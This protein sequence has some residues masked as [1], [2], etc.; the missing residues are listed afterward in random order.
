M[1]LSGEFEVI[2]CRFQEFI[3][4]DPDPLKTERMLVQESDFMR[5][6]IRNTAS[7]YV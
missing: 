6:R 7:M 2:L 4:L 1:D 3:W 5:I